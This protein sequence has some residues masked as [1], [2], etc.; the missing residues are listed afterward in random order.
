MSAIDFSSPASVAEFLRRFNEWRRDQS[1]ID[2]PA[3]VSMPATSDIGRAIA[4]AAR[5]LESMAHAATA[6]VE[7]SQVEPA[8]TYSYSYDDETFLGS[9]ASPEQAAAHCLRDSDAESVEV[10]K[11]Q[12]RTAHHYV[13]QYHIETLLEMVAEN[14]YEECGDCAGEWLH[15]TIKD[16]DSV[17]DLKR[18]IGA[19]IQ[20]EAPPGFWHVEFVRRITRAEL[21]A[22]G[23]LEA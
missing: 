11:N 18:V 8:P 21:V 4:A 2:Q 5:M 17:K 13:G 14:A 16:S 3:A 1:D 22:S 12:P 6:S 15:D 19:W 7:P 10:G 23:H 20:K 9:F